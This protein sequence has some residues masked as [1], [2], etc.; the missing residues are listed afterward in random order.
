VQQSTQALAVGDW[1]RAKAAA[2]VALDIHPHNAQ[3]AYNLA[4]V[5][6]HENNLPEAQRMYRLIL[7]T[8]S[9]AT[10]PPELSEGSK[11]LKLVDIARVKL[12]VL[13]APTNTPAS[14]GDQD[15]DGDGIADLYDRCAGTPAGARVDDL[16]CWALLNMF[17][18]DQ[19]TIRPEA[20]E[21][22]DEVVAV[23]SANPKLQV[24][25]QGHTDSSGLEA[26]NQQLSELRAFAVVEYLVSKGISSDRLFPKGYGPQRPRASNET[27]EGKALNRRVEF[28]SLPLANN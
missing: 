2:Q 14:G 6:E 15:T 4:C 12:A 3:A 28:V 9:Q 5:Y 21:Q 10:I 20:E 18:P 17:D 26:Y 19:I 13:E 11:R 16:G 1:G 8:N 25:V 7:Q 27:K 23:L 24:E 22:L